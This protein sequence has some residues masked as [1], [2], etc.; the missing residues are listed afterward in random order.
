MCHYLVKNVLNNK[1]DKEPVENSYAHDKREGKR[2]L[3]AG[4][5]GVMLDADTKHDMFDVDEKTLFLMHIIKMSFLT[6]II[7]MISLTQIIKIIIDADYSE[8]S[9]LCADDNEAAALE[10][11]DT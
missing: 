8:I 7:K 6:K 1:S 3:Y 2:I 5:K 10:V 4:S 9:T 11:G